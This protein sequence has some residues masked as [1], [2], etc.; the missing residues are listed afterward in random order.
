M[1]LETVFQVFKAVVVQMVGLFIICHYK[2]QRC[3]RVTSLEPHL[4]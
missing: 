1:E 3:E 2:Q 4:S